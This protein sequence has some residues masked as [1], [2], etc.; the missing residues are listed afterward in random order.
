MVFF[1]ELNLSLGIKMFK[2]IHDVPA[3]PRSYYI[4]SNSVLFEYK[5][6]YNL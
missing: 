6:R 5:L 3:Y 2:T 4:M 1:V